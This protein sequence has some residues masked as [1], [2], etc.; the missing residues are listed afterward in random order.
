MSSSSYRPM[1]PIENAVFYLGMNTTKPPFDNPKVR[2]AV[3]YAVPY[4]KIYENAFY[5]RAAK[6]YGASGPVKTIAWPQPTAYKTDIAKAKAL[7]AEAGYANGFKLTIHTTNGRYVNDTRLAQAV[8]QMLA[9]LEIEVTVQPVQ[10]A[11]PGPD[12]LHHLRL[13]GEGRQQ[14]LGE[15]HRRVV[16]Q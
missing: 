1:M 13:L 15:G 11:N 6:L 16:P 5:G 3:A 4:D 2:Q 8:A 10:I 12:Q 7:L 14:L 9:R